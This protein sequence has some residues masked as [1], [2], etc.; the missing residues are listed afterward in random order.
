MSKLNDVIANLPLPFGGRDQSVKTHRKA[1]RVYFH[2]YKKIREQHRQE[3]K[4]GKNVMATP[5]LRFFSGIEHYLLPTGQHLRKDTKPRDG[6][7]KRH[8]RERIRQKRIDRGDL[9]LA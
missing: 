4:E 5:V 8:R 3:K 1:V 6:L 7:G 9:V 2:D